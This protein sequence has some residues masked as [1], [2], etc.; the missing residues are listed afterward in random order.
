MKAYTD[1]K[2]ETPKAIAD[3]NAA[4]AKAAT[5]A[6]LLAKSN[7]TFDRPEADEG[8]TTAAARKTSP[9]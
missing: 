5:L 7:L 4:I 2:A 8:A 3:L 9:L 1:A 6:P